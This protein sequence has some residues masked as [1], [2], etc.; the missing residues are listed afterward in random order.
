[1]RADRRSLAALAVLALGA[2]ASAEPV[3]IRIGWITVPTSLAPILFARPELAPH[4]GKS[5]TI[6]PMHFTGSSAMTTA[7]ASGDLD[8][9]ELSYSSF[10]YAIQNGHMSDLRIIAD[11]IQDGVTGYYLD[12]IHGAER[13]PRSRRSRI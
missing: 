8:I 12:R 11:E 6:E 3:K 10:A 7:L 5:Y 1:M 13:R 4:L 9:A 2:A